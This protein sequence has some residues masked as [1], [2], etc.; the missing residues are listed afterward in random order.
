[1]MN[2][3]W[4]NTI[5]T[6]GPCL[7]PCSLL[8]VLCLFCV[9]LS[10]VRLLLLSFT[11]EFRA[12]YIDACQKPFSPNNRRKENV[13]THV[14]ITEKVFFW[15]VRPSRPSISWRCVVLRRSFHESNES[16]MLL[17]VNRLDYI[18]IEV[19]RLTIIGKITGGDSNRS[20][21]LELRIVDDAG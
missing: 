2:G 1:M 9:S 3:G 17:L 14:A 5:H 18:W 16:E 12:P 4:Q 7:S 19:M 13:Q 6:L 8:V 15:R 10:I 11:L 20:V 21:A